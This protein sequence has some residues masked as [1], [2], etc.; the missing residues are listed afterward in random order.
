MNASSESALLR[1]R[2]DEVRRL[3]RRRNRSI[4]VFK[5]EIW[6]TLDGD[7]RDIILTA[8]ES[9]DLDVDADVIVQALVPSTLLALTAA[10]HD[11][12]TT[13]A[14][15]SFARRILAHGLARL[16]TPST[17]SP[18]VHDHGARA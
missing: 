11:T 8:G 3:H 5:G 17:A 6:L 12:A 2:K 18:E 15:E 14:R 10:Y 4:A 1:L 9:L 13:P 7:R 16:R